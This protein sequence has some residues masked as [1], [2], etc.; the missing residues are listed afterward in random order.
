[1]LQEIVSHLKKG[2]TDSFTIPRSEVI[3]WIASDDPE[4]MG[5]AYTLLLDATLADRIVPAPSF[6]EIFEFFLR[7][8]EFCL[9]RDPQGEWVDDRF[10]AG[11]ELVR[12]FVSYW[13]EGLEEKYFANLKSLL[14]RL[15]LEGSPDL[16]HTIVQA[17]VEH[18]FET[19]PIRRFF[20][21]W[22]DDPQLREA[23]DQG[24]EWAAGRARRAIQN[25][26]ESWK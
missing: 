4:V 24:C 13:D 20:N 21:D 25:K 1:M 8:Y 23:Y 14:K 10:N 7:Y 12:F 5:A 9:R 2:K 15:Y 6:D 26:T 16:Q 11:C 22:R 17:I 18:L 3:Q 19:E